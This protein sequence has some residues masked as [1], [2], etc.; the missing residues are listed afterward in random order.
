MPIRTTRHAEDRSVLAQA[1]T[2]AARARSRVEW[3]KCSARPRQGSLT[4]RGPVNNLRPWALVER[5]PPH[6]QGVVRSPEGRP[7]TAPDRSTFQRRFFVIHALAAGKA[8]DLG[9]PRIERESRRTAVA[10][11]GLAVA[12]VVGCGG[13][14]GAVPS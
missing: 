10:A 1:A 9:E 11:N 2:F 7:S 3:T 8:R 6:D 13:G 4:S 12:F 14:S 5:G